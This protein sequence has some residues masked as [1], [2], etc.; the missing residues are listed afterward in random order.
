MKTEMTFEEMTK[1]LEVW[2]QTIGCSNCMEAFW[3]DENEAKGVLNFHADGCP[4]KGR[5][6][7]AEAA[8]YDTDS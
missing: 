1:C 7:V 8:P 4:L 5:A 3:G 6:D 2:D